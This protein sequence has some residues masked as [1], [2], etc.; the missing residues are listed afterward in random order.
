MSE[1]ATSQNLAAAAP[2]GQT[3]APPK[4]LCIDLFSGIAGIT[5]GLSDFATT[6]LYCEIDPHCQAVL[7]ERM[8]NGDIDKAPVHTDVKTLQLSAVDPSTMI[9]AGSPCTDVSAI[10]L[11]RGIIDGVRSN[12]YFEVLRIVDEN[13]KITTVFFE[14]VAGILTCGVDHAVAALA[15]RGF[16][17]QYICRSAGSM[18]APH[19]RNRWFCLALRPGTSLAH[20]DLT[21]KQ[22]DMWSREPERRFV[23]KPCFRADPQYDHVWVDRCHALG[24]TVV[25]CV[26]REAFVEL[27][28]T[29]QKWGMLAECMEDFATDLSSMKLPYPDTGLVYNG[30]FYSIPRRPVYDKPH[31]VEI[32]LVRDKTT[33]TMPN[34]PTPRR[35]LTHPSTLTDRSM[36][37][38][39]TVMVNSERTLS[40]LRELGVDYGAKPHAI[41]LP[42]VEYIEWLQGYASGWTK[43]PLFQKKIRASAAAVA[44]EGHDGE[45]NGA[46]DAVAPARSRRFRFNGM[47]LFMKNVHPHCDIKTVSGLWNALAQAERD[48]FSK[49]A[50]ELSDASVTQVDGIHSDGASASHE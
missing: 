26:V 6:T 37:D 12:L 39:P 3:N 5:L 28:R 15:S 19:Q 10:G 49:L 27:A 13:P 47:H 23:F 22:H 38:L 44:V 34:Y 16:N 11:Q 1:L 45:S 29:S 20:L 35:G 33:V 42:N 21:P 9:C 18:G 41:V 8:R 4:M 25:P 46:T 36:R 14:N 7:H 31:D 30:R 50:R 48:E 40:Q 2:P 17:C 43:A 24:N 32:T